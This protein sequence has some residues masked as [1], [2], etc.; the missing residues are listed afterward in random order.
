MLY[1][2]YISR[3]VEEKK[4]N[5]KQKED[6]HHSKTHIVGKIMAQGKLAPAFLFMM[7]W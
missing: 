2:N 6:I 4:H 5:E 3:K 7:Y 1:A